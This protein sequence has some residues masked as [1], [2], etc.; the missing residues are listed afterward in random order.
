MSMNLRS[1]FLSYNPSFI[2]NCPWANYFA[3]PWLNLLSCKLEIIII[4]TSCSYCEIQWDTRYS[5]LSIV[6][7]T[8]KALSTNTHSSSRAGDNLLCH[9]HWEIN[10]WHLT[11]DSFPRLGMI[12]R[13]RSK[14]HKSNECLMDVEKCLWWEKWERGRLGS[15]KTSLLTFSCLDNSLIISCY[16]DNFRK[17]TRVIVRVKNLSLL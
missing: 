1:D 3:S 4:L 10:N 14:M 7:G 16:F 6:S 15:V 2:A 11:P 9:S 17:I 5:V 8:K 13:S 12:V